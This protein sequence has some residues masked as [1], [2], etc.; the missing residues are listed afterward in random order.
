M[1]FLGHVVRFV[2]AALVLLVVGWIVPQFTIGG[3]WSALILAL[4]IALLGWVVEG[5]FGKKATPFGRGIVGFLVSALV[6][7]IAQFVVSGVSVT[8]LGALLAALVIGIIDLFLPVST[9]FEAGK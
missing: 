4:V 7:W 2:V 9:P 1:R 6:I 8:I 5:I 3:F